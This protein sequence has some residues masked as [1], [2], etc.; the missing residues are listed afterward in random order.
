MSE[1]AYWSDH[2]AMYGVY[3]D[4][5]GPPEDHEGEF[6]CPNCKEW[7]NEDEKGKQGFCVNCSTEIVPATFKEWLGQITFSI[8][9]SGGNTEATR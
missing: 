5:D 2:K 4:E 7:S 3:P 1:L 6:I 9:P 8:P